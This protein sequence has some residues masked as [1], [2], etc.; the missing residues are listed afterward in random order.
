[1]MRLSSSTEEP[2]GL[3]QRIAARIGRSL[4]RAGLISR[5]IENAYFAF[6]PGEEAPIHAARGFD[7]VPD[8]D[9]PER[10]D[11]ADGALPPP[12]RARIP[13]R[14]RPPAGNGP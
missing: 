3:V 9:G 10:A 4:E 12:T 2:K 5:D 14:P 11:R 7:H 6:D 8:R 13:A 1:M